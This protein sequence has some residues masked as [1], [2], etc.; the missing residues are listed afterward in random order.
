M[1]RELVF[2]RAFA[3]TI[4]VGM[5][6]ITTSGFKKNENQKFSEIDVE[7]INIV[8]ADGTVKMI[9]TNFERFPNGTDKINARPTNEE[10]KKRS[11]MLFFNE[12]GIE[13][14]GFIYDGQKNENGHSSGLSLTYDQYDG[15]QVMQLLTQDYQKGGDRFVSSSLAFNDRPSKESQIKTAEIMKELQELRMKDP[16]A[17]RLKQKEYENQGLIGGVP[18]IMLG[19]TR[20]Q[21]NGL[22]LFDDKGLP[23]A[24][25]Y[26]DKENNAKLDFYDEQG[27][28]IASF[29][30]N[31]K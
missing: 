25:F 4:V 2:L 27:N 30:E 16:K 23:K 9:I 28:T 15:D 3:V 7:R 22:F 1:K 17:M 14:G 5:I 12:D 6:L 19:K 31:K 18:R 24:M 11:G 8:E 20:S 29:P 26:V 13:C 10:R 21:N